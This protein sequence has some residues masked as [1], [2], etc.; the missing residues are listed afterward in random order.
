MICCAGTASRSIWLAGAGAIKIPRHI[1]HSD[2]FRHGN[3]DDRTGGANGLIL[4]Q[5]ANQ[6]PCQRQSYNQ[7]KQSLNNLADRR[8]RHIAVSLGIAPEARQAAD[9][10]H[11]RR[12]SAHAPNRLSI[13]HQSGKLR[14]KQQHNQ[15]A[16]HANGHKENECHPENLVH[17]TGAILLQRLADHF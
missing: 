5:Y 14:G 7:L 17:L 11:R 15:R 9:Q 2:Q 13:M 4:L 6:I 16:Y 8:R 10:S 1:K 3:A 12:Q